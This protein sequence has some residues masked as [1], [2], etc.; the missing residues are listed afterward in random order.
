MFRSTKTFVAA[1]IGVSLVLRLILAASG[2]Q[3][4]FGDEERY[5][6][7][8]RFYL[9][10]HQGNWSIWRE[11]ATLPGHVLY[12]WLGA[13]VTAGQHFLAQLTPYGDWS[14]PQ[15]VVFTMWLSAALLSLFSTAN[16]FLVYHLAQVIGASEQEARWTL[17]LMAASN[18]AF[19]FS[20]HL[21][22]YEPAITAALL[23][24]IIGLGQ[25]T[26]TRALACGLLAG[27]A[28]GIYNGYWYLVPVVWLAFTLGR[29]RDPQ[30]VLLSASCA[31]GTIVMV[32]GLVAAGALLGGNAYWS[33]VDGFS[34][35]ATFG[36]F[37][38]GWSLPWEFLW[39]SEGLAGAIAALAIIFA[40]VSIRRGGGSPPPWVQASLV[41][42][43]AAYALLTVFSCGLERFVVY[44][45]TVKPFL[46]PLCLVGGW[47]ADHLLAGSP[48][49]R[50]P[51][52]ALIV[53]IAGL[54]FW[55]HFT[56]VFPREIEIAILRH[57]GNPK[58]ALSTAG[59]L[60]VPLARPVTRPDLALVNAQLLF[61][62]RSYEGFPAG[63]TLLRVSHPL[64]Y[65]PFQYEGHSPRERAL[66]RQHDISIRLMQLANPAAV[67]NDPPP[68]LRF[69][70]GDQPTG[71]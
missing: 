19:Y 41:A 8:V 48:R 18:T 6:Y 69:R 30:R 57:W 52:A 32:G 40:V 56:R 62:V 2:G 22:P 66:L 5:D 34:R 71:Y 59:S 21:L 39:H 9:S 7:G 35:S 4:Y 16:V 60:Y 63:E 29:R 14:Q 11:M 65:P 68:A 25:P 31:A 33:A 23:G 24:L 46:V 45:R 15:N 43:V 47:A 10:L 58:R 53:L 12:P 20:R 54:H 28:Y 36:V 37:A 13:A 44:A 38:E 49:W 1:V 55:P 67:P 26:T 3:Y 17:L 51:A 70:P 50:L 27:V 64:S 61:P 42:L